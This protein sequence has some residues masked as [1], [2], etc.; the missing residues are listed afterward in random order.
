MGPPRLVLKA[1]GSRNV[2]LHPFEIIVTIFSQAHRRWVQWASFLSCFPG[3]FPWAWSGWRRAPCRSSGTPPQ[4]SRCPAG[5]VNLP[6]FLAPCT[7]VIPGETGELVG[8]IVAGHPVRDFLGYADKKASSKKVL[9]DVYKAGD[10]Y[11]R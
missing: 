4:G 3:S 6:S 8:K 11:F 10:M 1:L 9:H 7:L 2:L 5:Q